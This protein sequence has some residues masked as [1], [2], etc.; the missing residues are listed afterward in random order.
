MTR[1]RVWVGVAAAAL[2]GCGLP[3]PTPGA[4]ECAPDLYIGAGARLRPLD[5]LLPECTSALAWR[6]FAEHATGVHLG[7]TPIEFV[8]D[9][10]GLGVHD[11]WGV[12]R[13]G[14]IA[15]QANVASSLVHEAFHL[16]GA[17]HCWWSRD[18]VPI[19]EAYAVPGQFWDECAQVTCNS[20][21]IE[22]SNGQIRGGR[23][24]CR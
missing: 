10:D 21:G 23:Y 20:N 18:K 6:T 7:H 12:T 9:L 3:L 15:V 5:T 1:C 16:L 14:T 17:G 2:A 19:L 4:R 8:T 24:E 22:D 11:A 13:A